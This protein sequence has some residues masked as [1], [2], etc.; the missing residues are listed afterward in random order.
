MA[1]VNSN[2]RPAKEIRVILDKGIDTINEL[3]NGN[4]FDAIETQKASL[5]ALVKEYNVALRDATYLHLSGCENPLLE[6]VEALTYK[7]VKLVPVRDALS[8]TLVSYKLGTADS[9]ID[10][11]ELK[12]YCNQR[13]IACGVTK[14]WHYRAQRLNY[15]LA[16][17]TAKSVGDLP[18]V[19]RDKDYVKSLARKIE[20]GETPT[21]KE[22]IHV[23]LQELI[24]SMLYVGTVD[25]KGVEHNAYKVTNKDVNY[26]LDTF[27]TH[28]KEALTVNTIKRGAFVFVIAE[29]INKII[30]N[31]MYAVIFEGQ[32]PKDNGS[33]SATPRSIDLTEFYDEESDEDPDDDTPTDSKES[34]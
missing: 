15:L 9:N 12:E 8:K 22:K 13:G 4:D 19:M 18:I 6:A 11:I 23:A 7:R 27:T 5:D 1:K 26:L 33:G 29:I 14:D 16:V 32:K 31:R 34:D 2:P 30:N 24:D 17:A 21:S 3:L 28:G 20:M 10:F 25:K